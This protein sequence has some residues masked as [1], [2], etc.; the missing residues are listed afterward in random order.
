MANEMNS[1]VAISSEKAEV[2]YRLKEI[3]KSGDNHLIDA[4]EIINNL[5]G[6]NY[7]SNKGN[8]PE[9]SPPFNIWESGFEPATT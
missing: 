6:T 5:E 4:V 3:F 2:F 1:Y 7:S 8:A 9:S